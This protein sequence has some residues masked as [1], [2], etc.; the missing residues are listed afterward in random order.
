[1]QKKIEKNYGQ[2][3]GTRFVNEHFPPANKQV[4]IGE[5]KHRCNKEGKAVFLTK[6]KLVKLSSYICKEICIRHQVKSEERFANIKRLR[7]MQMQLHL[8][9]NEE[10]APYIWHSTR[11][12]PSFPFSQLAIAMGRKKELSFSHCGLGGKKNKERQ[13][14]MSKR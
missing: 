10:L 6:T 14:R 13:R 4:V 5:T 9:I 11:S 12:L 7:E 3:V 2:L 1:M 8:V